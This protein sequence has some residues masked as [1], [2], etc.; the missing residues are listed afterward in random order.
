MSYRLLLVE[1]C[2]SAR[3]FLRETLRGLGYAVVG[4]AID[5]ERGLH[6]AQ[7]LHPDLV[8]LAVDLEG[9]NGITAATR[10]MKQAPTPIILLGHDWDTATIRQ[11]TQAGV[12]GYLVK[13]VRKQ[14]LQPAVEL[15]VAR[16]REVR[17]LWKDNQHLR[18]AM[19]ARKKIE[20]A[21]GL[22][23]ARQGITEA[24]AFHSIQRQSMK[25]RT[26]MTQIADAIL[27]TE[28]VTEAATA[29]KPVRLDS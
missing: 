4:E 22:L 2:T 20:R 14:E 27:V 5:A 8:F 19:E 21:K 18:T 3:T 9:A 13:P 1:D 24:E 10:I 28:A 12:M 16:F 17:V 29:S 6:L 15:A 7:T 11:A 25:S 23:M 26:P